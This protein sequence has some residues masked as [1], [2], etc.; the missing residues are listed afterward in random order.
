MQAELWAQKQSAGDLM[1]QEPGE[2]SYL[3]ILGTGSPS[4]IQAEPRLAMKKA[5]C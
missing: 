2:G 1:S 5:N 3:L 4:E